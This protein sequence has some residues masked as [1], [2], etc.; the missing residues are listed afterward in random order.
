LTTAAA[1]ARGD[2]S[3]QAALARQR[4]PCSTDLSKVEAAAANDAEEHRARQRQPESSGRAD[5][6]KKN[7]TDQGK[8]PGASIGRTNTEKS[9]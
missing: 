7:Q 4:S 1:A 8:I 2:A 6:E 9:K 5:V 3:R